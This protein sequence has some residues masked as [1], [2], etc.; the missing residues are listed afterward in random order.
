MALNMA[1]AELLANDGNGANDA[2]KVTVLAELRVFVQRFCDDT[3]SFF[4][5]PRTI[6]ANQTMAKVLTN[7]VYLRATLGGWAPGSCNNAVVQ[8]GVTSCNHEGCGEWRP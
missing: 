7:C 8:D 3:V 6:L 5:V 2:I 1:T 4:A